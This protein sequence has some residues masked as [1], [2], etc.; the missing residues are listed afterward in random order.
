MHVWWGTCMR[1]WWGNTLDM[2]F[3]AISVNFLHKKIQPQFMSCFPCGGLN[4]G[5]GFGLSYLV[6]FD[7][8]DKSTRTSCNY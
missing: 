1:V 5:P 3:G 7:L 2:N 6:W 8:V 4:I